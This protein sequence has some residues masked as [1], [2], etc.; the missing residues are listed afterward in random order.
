[1]KNQE[2]IFDVTGQVF[3][4]DPPEGQASG[5]PTLSVFAS[6]V[7]DDGTAESATTGSCSVDSVDTTL[8]GAI[9]QGATTAT[10]VLGT[11]VTKGRRYRLTDGDG[12]TEW[13][14]VRAITGTAVT[15][16]HPVI[17]DYASGST[18]EGC[19]I[20]IS[21]NSTWVADEN[22]LTDVPSIASG[23][24]GYR[25]RWSYTVNSI[26]TVSVSYADLVRY[27]AKNLVTALDVDRRFPGWVDRLPSDYQRDQGAALVE[28]AYNAIKLDALGDDQV[29][30][31]IRNTEVL[32]E[33]TIYRANLIAQE[34]SLF[35]G[36]ANIEQ[37]RVA[38]E[39]Y[40]AR[41][42]RLIREPK[43]PVDQTGD[44]TSAPANRLAAW[45]R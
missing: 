32:R 33:L 27:Q 6:D 12:D 23:G 31:L 14:E 24:S 30:R 9:S 4:F 35:H 44:G 13:V 8:N 20:S 45:R 16:R 5:T 2:V 29:L 7:E 36:G 38:D 17:N 41:F 18:F 39:L 21:V 22:N 10:L 40:Q 25:L 1:V 15:F 34:A 43:V 26:P 37:V 11:G 3:Y 19:R 28:E 42:N